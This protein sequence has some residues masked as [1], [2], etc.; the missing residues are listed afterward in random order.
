[1]QPTREI[2]Q[3]LYKI[4]RRDELHFFG[5]VNSVNLGRMI[6]E[7]HHAV[8]RNDNKF[9]MRKKTGLAWPKSMTAV[10]MPPQQKLTAKIMESLFQ[11]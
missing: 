3:D 6:L 1:M 11:K 2:K 8:E 4:P 10:K 9:G 7:M 5:H